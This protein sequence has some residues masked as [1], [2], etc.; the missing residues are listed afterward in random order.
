MSSSSTKDDFDVFISFR[1][2]DTANFTSHLHQALCQYGIHTHVHDH[3]ILKD[4][5]WPSLS[6]TIKVSKVAI[7]VFSKNYGASTW[8]LKEL[9]TI[10]G[11]RRSQGQVV[12][13]V[14]YEVDP[15]HVRK[16]TGTYREAFFKHETYFGDK[17]NETIKEWKAALTEAANISGWDSH[18]HDHKIEPQFMEKIVKDVIEKLD[19]RVDEIYDVKTWSFSKSIELFSLQAFKKRHPIEGYEHL[20]RRAVDYARGVPLVLK[21]LGLNLHSESTEFWGNELKKLEN[22]HNDE[23][24]HALQRSY[25]RLDSIQKQI[26]LDIAFL[27][28]DECKD[29]VLRI[30]DACGFSATSGVQILEEKAL[31]TISK[32]KIKM[33]DLI[34]EMGLRMVREDIQ[35]PGKR[36]RLRDIGEVSDL[37]ENKKGSDAVEGITLDLSHVNDSLSLSADTFNM[38]NRLRFLKLYT[39]SGKRPSNLNYPGVLSKISDNLRY[40][41]WH[42]YNLKSLPATFSAK[43]LVEIHL[44][45]SHVIELWSGVQEVVNLVRIGL[46]EC[47]QLRNLPDLSKAPKLRWVNLSG[48][49]SLVALHTSL[50]CHDTLETLTLDGCKNLKSLK[51][52]KHL[53]SLKNINV[54]GSTSLKE[55]SLSS[56]SIKIL[57]LSNTG[58]K[59]LDSSIGRLRKLVSLNLQGLSL[60]NLPNEISSIK[61][62]HELRISNLEGAIEKNKLQ[63]IFDGIKYLRKLHLNDCVNLSELPDNIGG[64]LSL[65]EL[66]LDG[67][68]GLKTLPESVENLGHLETLSLQNCKKLVCL[69]T[70]PANVKVLNAVN[71]RELVQAS[72][73]NI[74]VVDKNG[75]GTKFISFENCVK[76]ERPVASQC[77]QLIMLNAAS[78]DE[79]KARPWVKYNWRFNVD[80]SVRVCLPGRVVPE[81]FTYRKTEPLFDI[82]VNVD[83]PC[84]CHGVVLC[85][86][87]SGKKGALLGMEKRSGEIWCECYLEDGTR[88][89]DATMPFNE[90]ITELNLDH[91]YIWYDHVFSD[92]LAFY[93]QRRVACKFV[94][95]VRNEKGERDVLDVGIKECGLR[96]LLLGDYYGLLH[97]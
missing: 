78:T 79:K 73:F 61:H 20:S 76:L 10:L 7:I 82:D 49:E 31:I 91:V 39:S 41:E 60:N 81:C 38:M 93:A 80:Q 86:V 51:G 59:T 58:I 28:K 18:S 14:F 66:K 37:L 54:H 74:L 50:L 22:H 12:I 9:V 63:V 95:C 62:L 96:L 44:P 33:H 42:G 35:D 11:C 55:F 26:F 6:Q 75:N 1:S 27:F 94:F 52:V 65:Q 8:C 4:E 46:Q 19:L 3:N 89:G 21:V 29:D 68:C 87:V 40:L 48:C 69:P 92:V 36:S 17:Q 83:S 71:C 64:L 85:V 70:L 67:C 88:V 25:D 34:Q 97:T 13:P 90:A 23:I 32:N 53:K 5:V 24:Q 15:S 57:D 30:L 47:K 56:D 72:V 77:T 2:E 45:H 16:R 43:M 84:G